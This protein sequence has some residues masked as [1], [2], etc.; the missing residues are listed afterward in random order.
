MGIKGSRDKPKKKKFT[1][2]EAC[3]DLAEAK[4][5]RFIEVPLG[6]KFLSWGSVSQADV[7]TIK[8]SYNRFNLD[9]YEVK[10]SRSDFLQEIKKKKYEA[11]L[12]HCNR[13]Y[14]AV[15]QGVCK[16]EEVPEGLGLIVRG[17]NG[18]STVKAAKKR[19]V[20]FD[21]NMLLSMI[22]FNGRVYNKKRVEL[23][24]NHYI[25]IHTWDK[26][27]LKGFSKRIKDALVNYNRLERQF[28]NLL[29]ES[30]KKIQFINYKARED[31]EDKWEKKMKGEDWW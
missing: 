27:R 31:F 20:D 4:G 7:V 1:H 23:S 26:D 16:A 11:S 28:Q 13:F 22:F 14:F 29:Y 8:P 21:K 6:S 10:V 3:F 24:R 2:R 19:T 5:T 18:W 17:D 25:N 9:I 15:L 30:S 12:P